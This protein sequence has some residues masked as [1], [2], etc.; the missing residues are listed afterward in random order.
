MTQ[1]FTVAKTSYLTCIFTVN[2]HGIQADVLLCLLNLLANS[3]FWKSS[4]F[5]V[6]IIGDI[7]SFLS[8]LAS[9]NAFIIKIV[10]M[11]PSGTPDVVVGTLQIS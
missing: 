4:T 9:N 11:W 5:T 8:T 10:K 3:Q 2:K 6:C 1:V 7:P